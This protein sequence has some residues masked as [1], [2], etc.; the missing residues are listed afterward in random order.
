MPWKGSRLVSAFVQL[1]IVQQWG[2][3]HMLSQAQLYDRGLLVLYSSPVN[4]QNRWKIL[5][6]VQ[7][8]GESA[9]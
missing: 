4:I 3:R 2:D 9:K 6:C 8:R 7:M 5:S 1:H